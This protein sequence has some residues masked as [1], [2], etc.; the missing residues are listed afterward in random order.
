MKSLRSFTFALFLLC[1]LLWIFTPA[2]RAER[3]GAPYRGPSEL[4]SGGGAG[5]EEG[6]DDDDDDDDGGSETE[7]TGGDGPTG[8]S[9]DGPTGANA[10]GP[11]GGGTGGPGGK[12]AKL[13]GTILW[14]WWWEHNKDRFVARVTA[15]GRVQAGSAYYWFGAGAKYPPRELDPVSDKQRATAVFPALKALLKDRNAAVRTETCTA[16]GRIRSVKADDKD[17]K[18]GASDNLVVRALIGAF[19][20]DS[21]D[22]VKHSALLAL[23]MT[24]SDDACNYLLR[25]VDGLSADE[26]PYAYIA[27]GL[28]RYMPAVDALLK[29]MPQGTRGKGS[30]DQL[31]AI[32][33]I[34]LYGP[35]VVEEL[36]AENRKGVSLLEKLATSRNEKIAVQAISTLGR[37]QQGLKTVQKSFRSKTNSVQW[38]SLLALGNYAADEKDAASASK[39]LMTKGFKSGKGQ[40]KNFSVLA[41]GELAGRLDPNSKTRKNIL[42]FLRKEALS[43]KNNYVR[44]C[45]AI[46]LGVADDRTARLAVAELLRDSTVDD[47]VIGAA[48][49]SLGLLRSTEHAD[50]IRK[51]VLDKTRWR[52]DA[53]GYALLG[54]AL[55][56][57]TTRMEDLAKFTKGTQPKETERQVSLA[58]GIL[59]DKKKTSTVA[60]YFS[61]TWAT[62]RRY[63]VSNAAFGLGW[64]KD[65]GAIARLTKLM[66][67]SDDKVRGMAAIALGYVGA[68]DRVN[69]LTRCYENL[70]Y[71]N[72]FSGWRVMYGISRIL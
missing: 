10:D 24:Q 36:T 27:L 11:S 44:A 48:C 26:K 19:E 12:T 32:H 3:V 22:G 60:G 34:G 42:K 37:I 55:M 69:P 56:G 8:E 62:N 68:R 38:T 6:D 51:S 52:P 17:K 15:G 43:T 61:T 65:Q 57:D 71:R 13:D 31:A 1:A 45:A 41:L 53:R 46:A 20:N 2:A 49:V 67:S 7:G 16:L 9:S 50:L 47:W 39:L 63:A 30:D 25:T 35:G 23:G 64:M 18:E 72:K 4:L 54:I 58:I 5:Q 28:A 21:N 33:A 14:Q 70:S 40:N 59:G 29:A 66:T